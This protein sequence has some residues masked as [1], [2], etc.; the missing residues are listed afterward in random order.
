[1]S[2]LPSSQDDKRHED[3]QELKIKSRM[4]K[5]KRWVPY[6]VLRIAILFVVLRFFLL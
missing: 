1:M 5:K 4:N 3:V 2:A 6:D